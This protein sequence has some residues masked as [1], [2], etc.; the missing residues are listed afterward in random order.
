M[1]KR[2]KHSVDVKSSA[3]LRSSFVAAALVL[4]GAANYPRPCSG[5]ADEI[6]K[7][8][9][10]CHYHLGD[11][12]TYVW[13]FS[14]TTA[15][16][17]K[18]YISCT[19]AIPT[20]NTCTGRRNGPIVVA[21]DTEFNGETRCLPLAPGEKFECSTGG[22]HVLLSRLHALHCKQALHLTDCWSATLGV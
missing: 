1:A 12:G 16:K 8:Q 7:R 9:C 22:E 13:P 2:S 14:T 21:D 10:F 19:T 5:Y 3:H 4:G 18:Q 6:V 17:C 11:N 20:I 15:T